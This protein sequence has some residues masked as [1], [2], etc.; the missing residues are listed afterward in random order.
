MLFRSCP[1]SL[2][3][4]LTLIVLSVLSVF[5]FGQTSMPPARSAGPASSAGPQKLTFVDAQKLL[6]GESEGNISKRPG[7][8]SETRLRS[9]Q[10]L[11][12]YYPIGVA[13]R[14]SSN[15]RAGRSVPGYGLLHV[16][17]TAYNEARRPRHILEEL[18]PDGQGFVAQ[19][20]DLIARLERRLHLSARTLDFS[21]GSLRRLDGYLSAYR[22]THTTA[23]T[24]PALFQE[25]TA[26]YGEVLRREVAGE[27]RTRNENIAQ[28][29]AQP[30]PN[31]VYQ[32]NG[33]NRDLKPWS[34]L[35]NVLYNED[36]RSLTVSAA[37]EA[38]LKASRL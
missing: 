25:M 14:H 1:R 13:T 27:W 6:E 8:Y 32:V 31:I 7:A 29:R 33:M 21:R 19:V 10:V 38:D 16:S 30:V 37:F 18:L 36:Q 5:T 22:R 3:A 28:K 35:L 9:G 15:S 24:D 34:S 2:T 20:P 12:L 23:D 4:F 17:V 26:Y 11:E